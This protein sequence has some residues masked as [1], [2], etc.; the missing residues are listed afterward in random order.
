MG[1]PITRLYA[2]EST[3]L[4]AVSELKNSGI[5]GDSVN[6]VSPSD[7]KAAT[8]GSDDGLAAAVEKGGV[9]KAAATLYAERV[10]GGGVVVTVNPHFGSARRAITILDSY[11][12]IDS[13]VS[14][15]VTHSVSKSAANGQSAVYDDPTPLS[16]KLNVRVL[17]DDPAPLSEYFKWPLLSEK[18]TP[19]SDKI[20]YSVLSSN[21]TPLSS[22][23]KL[24][25]L[26]D[27]AAP[28]STWLKRPLL[29]DDPTPFSSWLKFQVL[30]SDPT[31]L[32]SWLGWRTLSS[33]AAPPKAPSKPA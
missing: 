32:S 25:V 20:G 33:D 5:G 26:S 27:Q 29:S 16:S 18:A 13:G 19:F 24:S 28:F 11:N 22:W 30:S 15:E 31:P 8:A 14:E 12:P 4:D 7:A 10:R 17:L 3:A 2:N 9:S 23:L 1:Q 6:V 21:A